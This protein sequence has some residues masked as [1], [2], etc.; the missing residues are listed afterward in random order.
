MTVRLVP[1]S[2]L[3]AIPVYESSYYPYGW[4]NKKTGE[5]RVVHANQIGC[6]GGPMAIYASKEF[7]DGLRAMC[8]EDD[9]QWF[10]S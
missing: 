10:T 8:T 1:E 2:L 3:G 7:V 6:G 5:I 9:G 4:R